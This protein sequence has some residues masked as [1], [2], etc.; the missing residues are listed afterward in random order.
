MASR[1]AAAS[2]ASRR[3]NGIGGQSATRASV[4]RTSP[5]ESAAGSMLTPAAPRVSWAFDSRPTAKP[6]EA[7]PAA[8]EAPTTQSVSMTS[9]SSPS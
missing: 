4:S 5:S 9:A 6:S 8:S 7:T 2:A 1:G 3:S